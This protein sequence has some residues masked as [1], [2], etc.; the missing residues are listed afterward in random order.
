MLSKTVLCPPLVR[1]RS[2]YRGG[3]V[4]FY[5]TLY[6]MG[7]LISSPQTRSGFLPVLVYSSYMSIFILGLWFAMGAIG[8]LSSL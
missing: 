3:S 7:F 1:W 4:V 8:F 2:F 6:A 5:V